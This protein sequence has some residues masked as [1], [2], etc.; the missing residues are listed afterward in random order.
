MPGIGCG[1]G[2]LG[3]SA[4]DRRAIAQPRERER[5]RPSPAQTLGS[6]VSVSLIGAGA[7]G[8]TDGAVVT[9]GDGPGR[10]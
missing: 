7:A 6:Q 10:R 2:V 5:E 9:L 1:D 8:A 4:G 3:W